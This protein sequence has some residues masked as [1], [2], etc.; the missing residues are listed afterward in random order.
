MKLLMSHQ[1]IRMK[2]SMSVSPL[3]EVRV[4]AEL[5]NQISNDVAWAGAA[6]SQDCQTTNDQQWHIMIKICEMQG[7]RRRR[8]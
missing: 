2:L 3:Q 8:V 1:T 4:D 5:P 6:C 7:E